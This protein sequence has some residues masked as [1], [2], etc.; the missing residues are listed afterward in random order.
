M[1]QNRTRCTRQCNEEKICAT[2]RKT[3]ALGFGTRSGRGAAGWRAQLER[4]VVA[5]CG[6]GRP[7]QRGFR[8]SCLRLAAVALVHANPCATSDPGPCARDHTTIFATAMQRRKAAVPLR[9]ELRGCK[10]ARS[11]F[12]KNGP[13][14]Y[15]SFFWREPSSVLVKKKKRRCLK[16]LEKRKGR[17]VLFFLRK[18]WKTEQKTER[19]VTCSLKLKDA[20]SR[21]RAPSPAPVAGAPPWARRSPIGTAHER[22][23]ML[24]HLRRCFSSSR[25]ERSLKRG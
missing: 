21:P 8:R 12:S 4:R 5:G 16:T 17:S 1:T 19:H 3:A 13:L 22:P 23:A 7:N 18:R 20:R 6:A 14:Y 10:A 2:Q 9:P 24:R 25:T 11:R 15:R